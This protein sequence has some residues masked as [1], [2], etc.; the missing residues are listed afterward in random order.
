M[1]QL[2]ETQAAISGEKICGQAAGCAGSLWPVVN[3]ISS[4]EID[5]RGIASAYQDAHT[6]SFF[7][8]VSS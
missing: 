3:R 5:G 4:S 2:F 6:L 1:G 8:V 7:C